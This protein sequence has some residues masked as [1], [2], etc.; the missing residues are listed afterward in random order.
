VRLIDTEGEQ[1]GIVSLQE[2]LRKAEEEGLDLVEVAPNANPPV[3]R[4]MD[5]GK[6]KYQQQKKLQEAKKK[7][8]QSQLKE[9][10]LRP[11]IEE[12]DFQFKL[13]HIRRF[14]KEGSR[15]KVT[16]RFKGRE[17]VHTDLAKSV[18]VRIVKEV[19]EISR[20]EKSA[21]MQGRIMIMILAPK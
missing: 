18:L 21:F 19:E 10:K 6:Y 1:L 8:T 4:I 15:V 9:V 16:M 12:H 5:Y 11:K 20:L 2:A 14:L 17:I 3:C 7:Q 13:K